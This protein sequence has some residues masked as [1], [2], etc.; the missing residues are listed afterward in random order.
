MTHTED[1]EYQRL[2]H[3]MGESGDLAAGWRGAFLRTPRGSF[4][5]DTIWAEDGPSGYRAVRQHEQPREWWARVNS[6]AVVV[7]QLDDGNPGGPGVAT[8]SVSMPSLVA[9][10]LGH[11]DARAGHRVLEVGT[12]SGW[13]TALLCARVGDGRVTSVEIDGAVAHRAA[14]ALDHVGLRPRLLVGDGELG[15]AE[16]APYDRIASTAAVARVPYAWVAQCRPGALIVTPWGT[17]LCNAG[18]LRLRVADDGTAEGR[19]VDSVHFMWVRGQRPPPASTSTGTGTSGEERGSV[20][21]VRPQHVL[22]CVHAAFAV[23]LRVPGVRY[24][25][26][27]NSSDPQGTWRLV[28]WD[29]GGSRALVRVDGAVRQRGARDLWDEVAAARQWWDGA[30]RPPLTAF[31]VRVGPEGQQVRLDPASP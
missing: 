29:E 9:R 18:L 27:W 10:M 22:D 8:S 2:V 11:L 21:T 1:A 20:T 25:E 30:G 4:V 31:R 7:T 12:G 28:L 16:H 23:G 24:R 6:D 17:P 15:S 13:S 3:R 5:P 19:F 14:L 26:E